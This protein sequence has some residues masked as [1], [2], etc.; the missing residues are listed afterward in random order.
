MAAYDCIAV[1]G[2]SAGCVR[3]A[4]LSEDGRARVPLLVG[5]ARAGLGAAPRWMR[6]VGTGMHWG[7][8]TTMVRPR[9]FPAPA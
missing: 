6:L 2:G 7:D 1:G 8:R 4:R 5:E 3:A 9:G